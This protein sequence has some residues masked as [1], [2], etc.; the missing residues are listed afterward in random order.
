MEFHAY[1]WKRNFLRPLST[2]AERLSSVR[3]QGSKQPVIGAKQCRVGGRKRKEKRKKRNK[4][5]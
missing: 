4:N 3:C 2:T 1:L 5:S